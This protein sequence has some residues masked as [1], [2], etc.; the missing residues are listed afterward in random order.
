MEG[1]TINVNQHDSEV[2]NTVPIRPSR[3][4]WLEARYE[5]WD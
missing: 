3:K 1:T 2:S 5:T 4:D